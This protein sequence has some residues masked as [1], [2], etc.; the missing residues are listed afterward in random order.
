LRRRLCRRPCWSPVATTMRRRRRPPARTSRLNPPPTHRRPT[1]PP[2]T[3]WGPATS[4]LRRRLPRPNPNAMS[5][6]LDLPRCLRDRR[7]VRSARA[8]GRASTSST[9]TWGVTAAG[10]DTG[11]FLT[12]GCPRVRAEAGVRIRKAGGSGLTITAGIGSPRSHSPGPSIT[13]AAGTTIR[14]MAG[15]GSPET[16]GRRPG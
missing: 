8:S 14:T 9:M 6:P 5:L 15:S 2:T 13:T 11:T 1:R 3:T 10:C 7:P 4:L 16:P 12:S